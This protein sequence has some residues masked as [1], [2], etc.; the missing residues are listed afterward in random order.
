MN[1]SAKKCGLLKINGVGNDGL[2]LNGDKINSVKK[3]KYLGD[4]FSG[5]GD[6]SELCQDIHDKVEGT[7]T[8]LFASSKGINFGTKQIKSLLLLYK[9]V[10]LLRLIYNCEA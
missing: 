9:T 5:K 8:E 4:V 10:F 2:L 7:I 3:V 6:N 1:F